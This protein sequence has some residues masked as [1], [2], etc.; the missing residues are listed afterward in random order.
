M[1]LV[2]I[3]PGKGFIFQVAVLTLYLWERAGVRGSGLN[4]FVPDL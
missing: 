2:L 3:R 4:W 1:A